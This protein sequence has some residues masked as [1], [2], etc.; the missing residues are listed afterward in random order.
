MTRAKLP[1]RNIIP[2][3]TEFPAIEVK[4]DNEILLKEINSIKNR[5]RSTLV[6][7]LK[8][9]DIVL[10][11]RLA[12]GQELSK[13]LTRKEMFEEMLTSNHAISKLKSELG[14]ELM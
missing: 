8:N 1:R 3:I 10:N 11:I 12:E 6:Q 4:V 7:Y 5:I 14:L 2:T 9:K 13:A